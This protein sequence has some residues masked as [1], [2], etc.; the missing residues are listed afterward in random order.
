MRYIYTN[1]E[2]E[3]C[4]IC[5]Q[6]YPKFFL[7]DSHIYTRGAHPELKNEPLNIVRMCWGT[8]KNCHPK[9]EVMT[10]KEKDALIE[11]KLP[12]RIEALKRLIRERAQV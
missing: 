3:L 11:E 2:P 9:F 12:G 10:R 5:G 1:D 7:T 8:K 6:T 4:E